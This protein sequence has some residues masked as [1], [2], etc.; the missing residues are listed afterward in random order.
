[1]K[2]WFVPTIVIPVLIAISLVGFASLRGF[3]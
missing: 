1:M 3:L 2:V